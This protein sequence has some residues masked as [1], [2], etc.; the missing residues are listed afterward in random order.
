MPSGDAF[1]QGL[2]GMEG[3]SHRES[4]QQPLSVAHG[5]AS[6]TIRVEADPWLSHG[7][8]KGGKLERASLACQ[9]EC[10]L[11]L[12]QGFARSHHG[13]LVSSLACGGCGACS[14][15]RYGRAL[16]WE[17]ENRPLL[18]CD[19]HHCQLGMPLSH[20]PGSHVCCICCAFVFFPLRRT[21]LDNSLQSYSSA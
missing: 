10:G 7:N 17:E 20:A 11:G 2:A 9:C 18:L 14:L 12:A 8:R 15:G 21:F 19:A 1:K 13:P 4:P 3:L 6:S 5:P 16:G